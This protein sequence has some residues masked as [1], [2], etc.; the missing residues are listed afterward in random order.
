MNRYQFRVEAGALAI[1]TIEVEAR[2]GREAE[3]ALFATFEP[4]WSAA[5][6]KRFEVQ[7]LAVN[8]R[9]VE[10]GISDEDEQRQWPTSTE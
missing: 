1:Q 6:L 5:E 7:L 9:P 3:V 10:P 4:D 2:T 8:G